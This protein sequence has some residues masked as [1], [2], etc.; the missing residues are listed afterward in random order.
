MGKSSVALRLAAE[1]DA[2]I[3][4]ADSRHVYSGL[5]IG[6]AKP[7]AAERRAVPHH[8]LDLVPPDRPYSAARYAREAS[9]VVEEVFAR[10]RVPLV[11][12]GSGLYVKALLGGIFP[13]PEADEELRRRL[14]RQTPEELRRELEARDPE[15]ARRIHPR[16]LVRTVRALEV[17]HLTGQPISAWQ[18]RHAF[19]GSYEG[20][21][22]LGLNRERP[23]LYLRI[24]RRVDEMMARGL[25]D[26]VAALIRRGYGLEC[27]G[28]QTLGYRHLGR[29]LQGEWSL[30]E[31]VRRLKT[32]TKRFAKR[33]L[34]W[35]RAMPGVRWVSLSGIPEPEALEIVRARLGEEPPG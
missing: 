22:L 5:E 4:C 25:A 7:T 9:A 23:D 2:E 12:G 3:V 27:P 34:T 35:F 13:G 28:M 16:D 26:E 24:E 1:L 20:A 8:M 18:A 21:V 33:Q 30:E 6:T 31:T 17:F 14:R 10:G 29:F 11:V 32:D 19:P 15:A